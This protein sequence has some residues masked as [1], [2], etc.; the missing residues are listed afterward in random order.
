MNIK[1]NIDQSSFIDSLQP[2]D[3]V[4]YHKSKKSSLAQKAIVLGNK[5][6]NKFSSK[7][8]TENKDIYHVSICFL[9]VE[10]NKKM[11]ELFPGKR[12]YK[13]KSMDQALFSISKKGNDIATMTVVSAK[14]KE[15]AQTISTVAANHD[16][17]KVIKKYSLL[18]AFL[19]FFKTS[20]KWKKYN[21]QTH[22]RNTP[23]RSATYCSRFVADIINC[24]VNSVKVNKAANFRDSIDEQ[25]DDLDTVI[26]DINDVDN[27][28]VDNDD[29]LLIDAP[30]A[31]LEDVSGYEL[32]DFD[33]KKQKSK[34][35]KST[36]NPQ[37]LHDFL[38]SKKSDYYDFKTYEINLEEEQQKCT[39]ARLV[40][41]DVAREASSEVVEQK[42]S[43]LIANHLNNNFKYNRAHR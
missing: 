26:V 30:E 31:C 9:D 5:I 29:F 13:L 14:N 7:K 15:I 25:M 33:E 20:L 3:I 43:T 22:Y 40:N 6:G 18:G 10:G 32:V 1:Q 8:N 24:S 4:F 34:K 36:S 19:S 39:E 27:S 12:G 2:G 41:I 16:D 38:Q 35:M 37:S 17:Q 21:P 11:F 28:D 23:A 42:Q